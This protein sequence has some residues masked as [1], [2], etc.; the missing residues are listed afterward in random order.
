MRILIAED[1]VESRTRGLDLGADDLLTKPFALGELEARI[2]PLGR[3]GQSGSAARAVIGEGEGG[4]GVRVCVSFP[5][6]PPA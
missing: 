4:K 5:C 6:A 3:R 1:D 2:R